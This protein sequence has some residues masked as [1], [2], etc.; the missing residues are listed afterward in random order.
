MESNVREKIIVVRGA[1]EMASG[2]I[3]KLYKSGYNA[4]ALEQSQPVCVRRLVCF[5]NAIYEKQFEVEGVKSCFVNDIEEAIKTVEKK[6]IPV[7]VDTN[8]ESI[9]FLN[10]FAVIDGR[11]LKKDINIAVTPSPIFIGLGPGFTVGK[12][13]HAIVETNRGENMGKVILKG[14]AQKHTG[15]PAEVKNYT[16]ERILRSPTDGKFITHNSIGDLVKANDVVG[17]VNNI[18]VIAQIDGVIRGLI[19]KSVVAKTG[20]KIGD[21][22]PRGD[23]EICFKISDKANA[24]GDGVLEALINL[25]VEH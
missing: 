25:S 12:N 13:C 15:I 8:F 18:E 17:S 10:P 5:A 1:G 11:M 23:K 14:E 9:E 4:I 7:L 16:Y 21:I 24:I 3:N 19:H 20:Q 22:D 2:V 6:I